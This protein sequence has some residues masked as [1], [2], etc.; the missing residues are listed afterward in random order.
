MKTIKLNEIQKEILHKDYSY[1]D[2]ECCEMCGK[3]THNPKAFIYLVNGGSELC[4]ISDINN[5]LENHN[6]G[7]VGFR[8]IGSDCLRKLKKSYFYEVENFSEFLQD[9]PFYHPTKSTEQVLT[10]KVK[11]VQNA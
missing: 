7:I 2:S 9:N 1:F 8:N 3:K 4:K 10:E 11:E 6:E 5:F